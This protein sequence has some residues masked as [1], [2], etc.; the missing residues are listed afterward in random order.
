[1]GKILKRLVGNQKGQAL[2]VVL[3]FLA[4]GGLTIATLLTYMTT[5]LKAVQVHEKKTNEFYAADAGVE[6]AIHKIISGHQTIQDLA[7]GGTHSYTLADPINGIAPVSINILKHS[8]LDGILDPSEYQLDKPHEGW[9]SF[10]LPTVEE[11]TEEYVEYYCNLTLNNTGDSARQIRTLGVFFSPFPGDE[12]LIVGPS[13]I[14]YTANITD[15]NLEASSPETIITTEGFSFLWRWETTPDRGPI[16]GD[17]DTGALSFTLRIYDPGWE[18]S[19]FFAF[20]TTKE[21]DISFVTSN[22]SPYKWLIEAT[23]A[24]TEVSSSIIEY[25][26]GTLA[27]TSWE[28]R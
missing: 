15:E 25:I 4:I 6:D 9:F 11:Q 12:N 19:V 13:D 24:G 22:P 1:M 10:D 17:G 7:V 5:G 27:V 20:A 23:A 8:L 28:I 26:T 21:Q 2:I 18:Y 3:C 14:V 16:L